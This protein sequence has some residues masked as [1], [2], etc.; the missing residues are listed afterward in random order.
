MQVRCGEAILQKG[1]WPSDSS[2]VSQELGDRCLG[3]L[4]TFFVTLSKSLRGS[5]L[6]HVLDQAL[7]HHLEF[8]CWILPCAFEKFCPIC[9]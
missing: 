4:Q 5:I 9:I 8:V 6:E 3:L 1:G 7:G 2:A